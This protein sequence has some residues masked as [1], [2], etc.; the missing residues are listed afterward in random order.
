[1]AIITDI[2]E[3]VVAEM[4]GHTFSQ[5]FTAERR[6]R[7][8]FNVAKGE[9]KDLKVVVVHGPAI[10][11]GLPGRKLADEQY[12]VMVAVLQKP[13]EATATYFDPLMALV[14]EIRDYMAWRR[15]AAVDAVCIRWAFTDD[16]PF[17]ADIADQSGAFTGGLTLTYRVSR[18]LS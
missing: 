1:M 9:L 10:G 17:V 13:P 2:A 6:I 8:R 3:A 18:K 4:N 15:L 5:P 7:P 11:A 12:T 14:E 16:L